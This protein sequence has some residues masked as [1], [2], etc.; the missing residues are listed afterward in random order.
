MRCVQRHGPPTPLHSMSLSIPNS[1]LTGLSRLHFKKAK[2]LDVHAEV[3]NIPN[4]IGT[5]GYELPFNWE[6]D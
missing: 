5:D 3:Y 6:K 2:F 4:L 1:E